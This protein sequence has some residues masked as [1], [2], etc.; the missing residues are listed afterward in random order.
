VLLCGMGVAKGPMKI[1][2]HLLVLAISV[3]LCLA[4]SACISCMFLSG[5]KTPEIHGC[6]L[7]G[8]LTVVFLVNIF[9]LCSRAVGRMPVSKGSFLISKVLLVSSI[10]LPFLTQVLFHT[11]SERVFWLSVW[12]PCV[13]AAYAAL[14]LPY[15]QRIWIPRSSSEGTQHALP[16]DA[17]NGAAEDLRSR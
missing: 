12:L 6:V 13:L 5:Q 7:I 14:C 8:A 4:S 3:P 16:A 15:W 17:E 11:G 1:T 9:W 2:I 10:G